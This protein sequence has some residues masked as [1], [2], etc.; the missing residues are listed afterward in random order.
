MGDQKES[1]FQQQLEVDF[2]RADWRAGELLSSNR[3]YRIK[4]QYKH[5]IS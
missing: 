2:A 3:I 4:F 5:W 1:H